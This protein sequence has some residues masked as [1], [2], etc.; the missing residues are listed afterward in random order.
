MIE[1]MRFRFEICKSVLNPITDHFLIQNNVKNP[2]FQI[3]IENF[4]FTEKHVI[5][6]LSS[7]KTDGRAL[8]LEVSFYLKNIHFHMLGSKFNSKERSKKRN[9][10]I[11]R[12]D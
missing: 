4:N 9:I 5:L 11:T 10:T 7:G 1:M 3:S 8:K 12:N 2:S 6:V